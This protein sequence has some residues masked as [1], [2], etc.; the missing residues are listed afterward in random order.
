[1]LAYSALLVCSA[2]VKQLL[3]FRLLLFQA[4]A[5]GTAVSVLGASM[6]L[7]GVTQMLSQPELPNGG[8]TG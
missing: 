6:M 1:M 5:V 2:Q 3:V 8:G 4:A 7:G